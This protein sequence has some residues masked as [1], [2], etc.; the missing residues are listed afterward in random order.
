MVL[1]DVEAAVTAMVMRWQRELLVVQQQYGFDQ[2]DDTMRRLEEQVDAV[3]GGGAAVDGG[4]WVDIS[5]K[6]DWL[7]LDGS[8]MGSRAV[9]RLS[10]VLVCCTMR[11][12]VACWR[13]VARA[14]RECATVP[15]GEPVVTK[16][17]RKRLR[18]RAMALARLIGY[19]QLVV[20]RPWLYRG[21]MLKWGIAVFERRSVRAQA[22]VAATVPADDLLCRRVRLRLVGRF[23]GESSAEDGVGSEM[24]GVV[25]RRKDGGGIG[26]AV[27]YDWTCTQCG[28]GGR[29]V[30]AGH[31]CC[32]KCEWQCLCW[33]EAVARVETDDEEMM[34]RLVQ[35]RPKSRR[36]AARCKER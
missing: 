32:T 2:V 16:K 23:W 8:Q 15:R 3:G 34:E 20:A 18:V 27:C 12:L 33:C 22:L 14:A 17:M 7:T 29:L 6:S 19:A 26:G 1:P 21:A 31:S 10:R 4:G 35:Q 11:V 36:V 24:E 5:R 13:E 9:D 25:Q 28:W 30:R